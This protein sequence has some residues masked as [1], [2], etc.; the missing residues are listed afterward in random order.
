[1]RGALT[2]NQRDTDKSKHTN[3]KSVLTI[4]SQCYLM[5]VFRLSTWLILHFPLRVGG[6][7]LWTFCYPA[8]IVQDKGKNVEVRGSSRIMLSDKGCMY[9]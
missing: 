9:H 6:G 8:T 5:C 3:L 1:M 2:P 4:S 7:M